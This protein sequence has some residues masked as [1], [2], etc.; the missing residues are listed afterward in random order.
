MNSQEQWALYRHK[1]KNSIHKKY[2]SPPVRRG[3]ST[4]GEQLANRLMKGNR[5]RALAT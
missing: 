1:N 3:P 2:F 5:L 4:T